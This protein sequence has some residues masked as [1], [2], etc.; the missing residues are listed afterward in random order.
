M[1]ED[2]IRQALAQCSY[3]EYVINKVK[4]KKKNNRYP[5][6]VINKVK[7]K[8]KNNRGQTKILNSKPGKGQ[9]FS[10]FTYNSLA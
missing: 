3:P 8:K 7:K 5:E 6:Y 9:R 4:K 10:C 1:E 2:T